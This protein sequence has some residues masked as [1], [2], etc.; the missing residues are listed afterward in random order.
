M[1]RSSRDPRNQKRPPIIEPHDPP[2]LTVAEFRGLTYR[3]RERGWYVEVPSQSD[4]RTTYNVWTGSAANPA[5]CPC[6]HF[7]WARRGREERT[8]CKHLRFVL[9]GEGMS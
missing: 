1:I 3:E 4:P 9:Y 5:H 8:L 6:E 7:H 2:S